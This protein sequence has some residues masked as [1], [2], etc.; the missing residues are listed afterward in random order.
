MHACSILGAV[1]V[2][3]VFTTRLDN[4]L[5]D[6]NLTLSFISE[7]NEFIGSTQLILCNGY[8][9]GRIVIPNVKFMYQLSGHDQFG[10]P[11]T[12]TKRSPINIPGKL[13]FL[14][15]ILDSTKNKTIS[16]GSKASICFS[17]KSTYAAMSTLNFSIVASTNPNKLTLKH[18]NTVTV[19][20]NDTEIIRIFIETKV[21]DTLGEYM[22]VVTATSDD[23]ILTS[24]QR[25]TLVKVTYAYVVSS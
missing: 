13:Y 2:P 1:S 18:Q 15:I 22:V 4:I 5:S 14:E 9:L 20:P 10:N 3:S 19:E 23:L 25:I 21:S 6:N 8:L 16:T 17:L 7:D 11:F 12:Y 24:S